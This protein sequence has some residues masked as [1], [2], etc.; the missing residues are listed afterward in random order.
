MRTGPL[1]RLVVIA[2]LSAVFATAVALFI[3]WL[4]A[5]DSVQAERIH[6]VF[7]FTTVICIAIFAVVA[8]VLVY[9]V[10]KFRA[11]PDDDSDG[12]PVHGHTILEIWWTAIP[13]VLVTAIAI[14]SAIALGRNDD[15]T[16]SMRVNVTAQQF[17]W[18]FAYPESG[19]L[20]STTLK[21]QVDKPVKLYMQAKD[22]LHSF[23]VPEFSQKQDLV[24][25]ETTTL[26]IT[27]QKVGTYTLICT[28]LCGLGHA[29]MRA[30][31]EV[32][33]AADFAKWTS[34]GGKAAAAGGADAGRS[35]FA[36]NGCGSCHTFKPAGSTGKIGPDLDDMKGEAAKAGE[37]LDQFVKTSIVDPDAHVAAGYPPNVMPKTYSSL[38]DDQVDALV[39]Y[40]T[41]GA[42]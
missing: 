2:V 25:G 28:E 6:W 12:A 31:V 38:P 7:W 41:K 24:P 30:R 4:P 35:I 20:T 9:C 5:A 10:W 42:E 23:W 8:A 40:L 39:Q 14:V 34:A 33:S 3:P 16:G 15:E 13:T 26:V 1:L 17:A 18:S 36:Q 37:P 27:P 22:V 32:L 29:V 21:L 19:D 11:K